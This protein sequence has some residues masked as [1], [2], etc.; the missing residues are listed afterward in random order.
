[1]QRQHREACCIESSWEGVTASTRST[2]GPAAWFVATK[3][4]PPM[5]RA[6]TIGR[7]RLEQ[8]LRE[9]VL[10]LP[11]TLL[12]APAGY[13]KTTMLAALPRLVPDRPL[14][15]ITLDSEDNDPIRFVAL[16]ATALQR[17]H[18][19]VGRAVWPALSSGAID[20]TGI[21]HAVG[22]LINDVLAHVPDDF[23]LVLDDLHFVIE[24][25]VYVALDY[26]LDHQPPQFHLAIGTRTDPP[27][28][29]ARLAARR[30]LGE[31][32]RP[33]LGFT[34]AES[35]QLLNNTLGLNLSAGELAALQQ[36][37]E[38]WPA[39]LCLIAGPL[40]RLDT[41]SDRSEFTAA[42]LQSER[43]AL[44]FL[45]EEVLRNMPDETR[46]FLLETSIL[47][48][49]TPAL[50]AA[51]TGRSDAAAM[52]DALYRQNLTTA[53]LASVDGEPVYR[54]H[55][56]FARLLTQQLERELPGEIAAL[57]RRAAAAERA[58]SRAIAHYLAAEAWEPAIALMLEHGMELLS[59]GMYETVR[60]WWDRLPPAVRTVQPR[61][62]VLVARCEIHRGDYEAAGRLLSEARQSF[63]AA[64]DGA[65]EAEA[66][67]SL[68]TLAYQGDDRTTA[69]AL[70]QRALELP[71]SHFGQVAV[72]LAR[73]WVRLE[74]GDWP[75]CRADIATAL[76][77]PQATGDR[78]ADFIGIT[79]MSAPMAAVPGCLDVT[80]RYA[81]E[82]RAR[83]MPD[84]AWHLGATE[85]GCWPLLWRGQLDEA[86]ADAARA[87]SLRLRLGGYPF[88]G[89]DLSLILAMLHLARG[90]RDGAGEALDKLIQRM[91][92]AAGGKLT[93][94]MHGAGKVAAL[95]GRYDE[96]VAIR[97]RLGDLPQ[98]TSLT[99]YLRQ[100]LAGLVALLGG[101]RDDAASELEQAA[102]LEA[103]LSI[104]WIGG[105]ASLLMA[106]L[107][108]DSGRFDAA[109]ALA[110]ELLAR[111]QRAGTPG[112]A[113]LDGP[114]GL[115]V[116]RLA[117]Q[118]GVAGAGDALRRFE[119]TAADPLTQREREV[120]ALIVA[121]CT[122]RQIAQQLYIGE[123]T[124]KSHVVHILRKLGVTSRTQA[125]VR[126]RELGL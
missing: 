86:L 44:D 99:V 112:C 118:R 11:L 92:A 104:A 18:P 67:T 121:G 91:S 45:A 16:I 60:G 69:A 29:L 100:H 26:L 106:R 111:W 97:K 77:I 73:A 78:R 55:A 65:G 124:V 114:A 14:A 66:L 107:A 31:L 96:A 89:A 54:H 39:G 6:D 52:L 79:Y 28:R 23:I 46:R 125:A 80:E 95:L 101:Q 33:D 49:M 24:P 43:Y 109:L 59:R 21:K 82:A 13:G 30:Q 108:L 38:G 68:I 53:S 20:T 12:S 85:L 120:L 103:S 84:T 71:L 110:T 22:A 116:F 42:V 119:P 115:P 41:S 48:D 126:G 50:C 58:P 36:R 87:E 9:S 40:A 17:L 8:A 88:L 37:T 51:V 25:A 122:N 98:P 32:R 15:W 102:A 5:V 3:F 74:T 57:H 94:Y 72:H 76:A 2:F 93:F 4:T 62:A 117:A 1:M 35:A 63:I 7:P 105:S 34:L 64:G 90:D 70:V 113:I 47:S 27:L 56:L 81:R 61:L 83:A 10:S 123:E 75:G 19:D